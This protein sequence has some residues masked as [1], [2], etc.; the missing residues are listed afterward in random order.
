MHYYLYYIIV[1]DNYLLL[2]VLRMYLGYFAKY[3]NKNRAIM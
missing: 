2:W 1:F 3:L